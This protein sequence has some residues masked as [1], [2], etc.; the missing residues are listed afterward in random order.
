MQCTNKNF[1][2]RCF[3]LDGEGEKDGR[4][5]AFPERV[6]IVMTYADMDPYTSGAVNA[7]H[8]FRNIADDL[9]VKIVGMVYGSADR[10][11]EIRKNRDV[12]EKA[13]NLGNQLGS[14]D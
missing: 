9:G 10:E 2:D 13:F 14:T 3:A 11:G 5:N 1:I 12:M 6:G 8:T 7:F 4:T